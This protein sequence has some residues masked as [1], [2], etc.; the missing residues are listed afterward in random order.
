[1]PVSKI[2]KKVEPTAA[3]SVEGNLNPVG[4]IFKGAS[5]LCCT[6]NAIASGQTALG[7]L[8]SEAQLRKVALQAGFRHFRRVCQSPFNR[9]FEARPE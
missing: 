2:F 5:V 9:V 8:A 1:V 6:P 4:R 7:T 3:E